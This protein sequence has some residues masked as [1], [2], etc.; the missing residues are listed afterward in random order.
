VR[1]SED[2]RSK[3]VIAGLVQNSLILS[4]E[5]VSINESG[6][7][8]NR[9]E[10]LGKRLA[11]GVLVNGVWI[12]AADILGGV[13]VFEEPD[14][15]TVTMSDENATADLLQT[16]LESLTWTPTKTFSNSPVF[17]GNLN[18]WQIVWLL[19]RQEVVSIETNAI[20][21]NS[22]EDPA[23]NDSQV[24]DDKPISASVHASSQGVAFTLLLGFGLFS[25]CGGL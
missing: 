7:E 21:S 19:E 12:P 22:T 3:Q 5:N 6:S 1:I 25:G 9:S 11:A 23:T 14:E 15:Y 20:R 17:V 2:G 10:S 24:R 4:Q 8:A 13:Y 16:M 18:Q